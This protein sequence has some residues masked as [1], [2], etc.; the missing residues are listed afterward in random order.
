[1][2]WKVNFFQTTRK[3]YPVRDFI[4]E[5][6]QTTRAKIDLYFNLLSESG[7]FLKPPYIKKIHEKL[8]ELRVTGSISVRIFYTIIGNEYYL[9]HAFKKQ[10]DKTPSKEIKIALDRMRQLI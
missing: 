4:L 8:Y 1:M 10:S 6:E 7:P 5:Q 2:S 3:T 9:L